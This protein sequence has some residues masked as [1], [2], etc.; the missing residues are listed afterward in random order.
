MKQIPWVWILYSGRPCRGTDAGSNTYDDRRIEALTC[1][2]E[3]PLKQ[4]TEQKFCERRRILQITGHYRWK[5][6]EKRVEEKVTEGKLGT[7]MENTLMPYRG[8]E[9]K[10]VAAS[11]LS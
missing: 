11:N 2:E 6:G 7:I 5:E 1:Q 10:K 9:E 3:R 8:A 4:K